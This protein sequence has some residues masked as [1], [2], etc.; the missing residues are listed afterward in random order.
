MHDFAELK[1][2]FHRDQ[3]RQDDRIE[4]VADR[5]HKA[6]NACQLAMNLSADVDKLG[7]RLK[8]VEALSVSVAQLALV[9]NRLERVVWWGAAAVG[10]SVVV[11]LLQL[12]FK[13]TP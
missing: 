9:V 5:A 8:E 13:G 1:A 11:Q 4:A 2:D 6:L 12:I 7:D 3:A 10:A